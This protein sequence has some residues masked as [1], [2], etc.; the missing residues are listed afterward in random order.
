MATSAKPLLESRRLLAGILFLD[1]IL[2]V[3]ALMG[4]EQRPAWSAVLLMHVGFLSLATMAVFG[5]DKA[6][7]GS[8]RRRVSERNLLLL[9]FLG[10]ALGGLMGLLLFRHKTQHWR[11]RIFV[12]VALILHVA[13]LVYLI[14]RGL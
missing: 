4:L 3:V 1:A 6:L 5:L 7:A 9:S 2:L 14:F 8:D 11:F 12:P 10:G 13:L